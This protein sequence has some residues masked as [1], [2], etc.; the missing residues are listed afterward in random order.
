MQTPE[1]LLLELVKRAEGPTLDFKREHYDKSKRH[2]Y[3][4]DII[5]M[6]NTPRDG[7]A[8][9]VLGV[10]VERVNGTNRLVGLSQQLDDTHYVDLLGPDIVSP[11]PQLEYIP[12]CY[13]SKLFGL[14][15]IGVRDA[16]PFLST[17]D[18]G[19]LKQGEW[20]VRRSSSN[21]RAN[22]TEVRECNEWF[23]SLR[24]RR[25]VSSFGVANDS[26]AWEIFSQA[27]ES[28]A[29]PRHF[30]L[31]VDRIQ[32]V[33]VSHSG[34]ALAPWSLVLDFDPNSDQTGLLS[35]THERLRENRTLYQS[36]KGDHADFNLR[37]STT[38]YFTRGL[39]GSTAVPNEK[40]QKDWLKEYGAD[41][42]GLLKRYAEAVAPDPVTVVVVWH[43]RTLGKHLRATLEKV[44]EALGDLA[45]IV[46]ATP[47][48]SSVE[49]VSSED[50]ATKVVEI[51][52]RSIAAGLTDLF[53]RSETTG[54][55]Y[56]LP[57]RTGAPYSLSSRDFLWLEEECEIVHRNSWEIGPDSPDEFRRGAVVSWRDLHRNQDCS[58]DLTR[59][60]RDQVEEDL[61]NH[62]IARIN[63]FHRPGAG[64]STVARRVVWELHDRFPCLVMRRHPSSD[65]IERITRVYA[66]T[67]NSVLILIDGNVYDDQTT[68]DLFKQLKS[69]QTPAVLLCVRRRFDRTTGDGQRSFRLPEELTRK[70]A[71][72]F[73]AAYSAA[74]PDRAKQLSLV[75]YHN[76]RECS[77]FFFGLTAFGRDFAGL[78]SYVS[79]RFVG[80]SLECKKAMIFLAIAHH[81]AQQ[82]IPP[83]SFAGLLSF[84]L[85][86]TLKLERVLSLPLQDLLV[87]TETAD[88]RMAH[89]LFAEECLT[90][91]LAPGVEGGD[92]DWK[93]H[94]SEWAIAFIRFSR[95]DHQVPGSRSIELIRDAFIT[96]DRA[97]LLASENAIG[98]KY[99]PL[100]EDIPITIGK[101][102]VIRTLTE[103]FPDE[104]HFHAHLGRFYGLQGK[105]AESQQAL[106]NALRLNESDPTLHHML[107]MAIRYQVNDLITKRSPLQ[108]VVDSAKKAST[109]FEKSRALNPEN[110]HGYISEIQLLVRT[111]DYAAKETGKTVASLTCQPATDAYLREAMD[112]A[113]YL[114]AQVRVIRQ[115]ER[116]SD[117][118]LECRNRLT[119]L[120]G[121]HKQAIS[122]W[123]ALLNRSGITK[124]PIRRQIAWAV[125]ASH[126]GDWNKL[127][128]VP[129]DLKEVL[130]VLTE[131][132]LESYKDEQSFRLWLRVQRL[133]K[134]PESLDRLIELTNYWRL[135]TESVESAFYHYVLRVLSCLEG[136]SPL[137][138]RDAETAIAHCRHLARGNRTRVH[139]IEWL[140]AGSSIGRLVHDTDL[141]DWANGFRSNRHM[142]IRLSGRISEYNSPQSGSVVIEGSGLT[143]FFVP[144]H[145]DFRGEDINRVVTFYLGFRY[146]GLKAWDVKSAP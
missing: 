8:Y 103:V 94:L 114:L 119:S 74:A 23:E 59:N 35:V 48:R 85:G 58:R 117:Y 22:N 4:K 31:I 109:A 80:V 104:A 135:N 13:D 47:D 106:Y 132:V 116:P 63:I 144:A 115:G 28:F 78:H 143:A 3:I 38:W 10:D 70:E 39:K 93:Q 29:P 77:A 34:F 27:C 6:S 105:Y 101:Q 128:N 52:A 88:W 136:H 9:I 83:Q 24:K 121:N 71:D 18:V 17:K 134:A 125:L 110:E 95:G 19:V 61:K 42:T 51:D 5:A 90:H 97:D 96:R 126:G 25:P 131:N 60:V 76:G 133:L 55:Q 64:A 75:P 113:E 57:M 46:L 124:A 139:T 65:T 98:S 56:S 122:G 36:K 91:L 120:Y 12:V 16:G 86:E 82:G 30:L 111:L 145:G 102:N 72:G 2:E 1:T 49:A 73:R 107:G 41:L 44:T 69:K 87:R 67:N 127:K 140:G 7:P 138:Q 14:L 81:Y 15:K 50:D 53:G 123:F 45:S 112:K 11:L 43:D 129:A 142:L 54:T 108:D 32:N 92:G 20:W 118:E 40:I 84:P 79:S 99:A 146:E 33:D 68:D 130:K 26:R 66:V 100:L 141:G 21:A 37:S 62:Q 89:D 137:T